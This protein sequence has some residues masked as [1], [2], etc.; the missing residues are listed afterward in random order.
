MGYVLSMLHLM[1]QR[2]IVYNEQQRKPNIK[3]EG[4][5]RMEI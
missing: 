3:I 5:Y 4:K 2:I 1:S